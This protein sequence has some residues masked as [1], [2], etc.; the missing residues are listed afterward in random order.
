VPSAEPRNKS[1]AVAAAKEEAGA[2]T[3]VT[4]TGTPRTDVAR[5]D[6]GAARSATTPRTDAA[7]TGAATTATTRT[8]IAGAAANEKLQGTWVLTDGITRLQL[9]VVNNTGL[10]EGHIFEAGRSVTVEQKVQV[11]TDNTTVF[12]YGSDSRIRGAGIVG[13]RLAHKPI[14]LAFNFKADGSAQV[15]WRRGDADQSSPLNV[16]SHVK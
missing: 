7:R 1:T 4:S 9:T 12:V 2:V 13:G 11:R 16:I 15:V 5:A 8:A 10:L 14:V 6:E 3:G